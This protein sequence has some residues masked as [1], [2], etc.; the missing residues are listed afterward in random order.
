MTESH[1]ALPKGNPDPRLVVMV[2]LVVP[3]SGIE[4]FASARVFAARAGPPLSE[5][6]SPESPQ[7]Q[8]P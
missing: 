8:N 1:A 4:A 7:T 3:L 6:S 5:E 2:L